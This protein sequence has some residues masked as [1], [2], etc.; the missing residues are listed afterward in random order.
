MEH[1]KS[2]LGNIFTEV[3]TTIYI[4][5]IKTKFQF[6]WSNVPNYEL[7]GSHYTANLPGGSLNGALKAAGLK[8]K[9]LETYFDATTR[10]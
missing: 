9:N 1:S 2:F 4:K 3:Q 10:L 5:R 7:K 6:S 8:L